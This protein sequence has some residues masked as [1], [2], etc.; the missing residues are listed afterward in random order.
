M[1]A[2]SNTGVDNIRSIIDEVNFI[3]TKLKY[4]VYIIDEAH[5]LSNSAWNAFLKTLEEPP[6][7]VKFILAT[8]EPQK[9]LPT[10][11]SRCQRFDFKKI[12]EN[13]IF[14]HLKKISKKVNID[15]EENALKLISNLADG[16]MRDGISILESVRSIDRKVTLD[17]I[18]QL[19]GIP[20]FIDISSLLNGVFSGNNSV[21]IN[22][23]NKLITSGKEASNIIAEILKMIETLIIYTPETLSKYNDEEKKEIEKL[24]NLIIS[25]K[26][27]V[28][29]NIC[30]LNDIYNN[31][32]LAYN[33]NVILLASLIA[34]TEE[35]KN[36]VN[37]IRQNTASAQSLIN[38]IKKD[39]F[40][41][42]DKGKKNIIYEDKD[43]LDSKD[44]YKKK[45]KKKISKENVN[46]KTKS[47]ESSNNILGDN[48][49]TVDF[50]NAVMQNMVQKKQFRIF[51]NLVQAKV[52][53]INDILE[54]KVT[55]N[56]TEIDKN[57]LQEKATIDKIKDAINEET[58]SN[59]N[60][61]IFFRGEDD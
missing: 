45:E 54:I 47:K 19:V 4:R 8:T 22:L 60:I 15:L 24:K 28:Y 43:S 14:N 53:I 31:L 55:K 48:T 34:I 51:A 27:D 52:Q 16:S 42:T 18:R 59:L 57:Y 17:D 46:A 7:H 10:I 38:N 21:T 39:N 20:N 33:K 49:R 23:A 2:A 40:K 41:K 11:L 35:N 1:D 37:N 12:D 36:V 9:I 44:K 58:G 30:K 29:M 6:A 32:K 50:W 13:D 3:P 61:K 25:N 56:L 26:I 5:M